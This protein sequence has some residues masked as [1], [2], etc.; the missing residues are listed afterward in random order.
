MTSYMVSLSSS[1]TS[2]SLNGNNSICS[3]KLRQ[4]EALTPLGV[5]DITLD[6]LK[7]HPALFSGG[8]RLRTRNLTDSVSVMD[9]SLGDSTP[10]NQ[11]F[12][13]VRRLKKGSKSS[14]L[15]RKNSDEIGESLGLLSASKSQRLR[16]ALTNALNTATDTTGNA[17]FS[18]IPTQSGMLSTSSHNRLN[19]LNSSSAPRIKKSGSFGNRPTGLRRDIHS[20]APTLNRTIPSSS[21]S[22]GNLSTASSSSANSFTLKGNAFMQV[23]QRSNGK[24]IKT[25]LGE[26]QEVC[27]SKEG[28]QDSSDA[29]ED[30]SVPAPM[31]AMALLSQWSAADAYSKV[32]ITKY[33]GVATIVNAMKKF[34]D[35][36]DIQVYGC[37]ILSNL[38]DKAQIHEKGGVTQIIQAMQ[39]YPA[40]IGVQSQGLDA[41]KKQGSLLTK[42]SPELLSSIFAVLDLSKDVFLTQAGKEGRA[43]LLQFL[44]TCQISHP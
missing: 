38:P 44:E 31:Q 24:T 11:S 17:S 15:S 3:T 34:H 14:L 8:P 18:H 32:V 10:V 4:D 13:A 5:R 12:P 33:N 22:T 16:C 21:V 20:S 7:P 27:K 28:G 23:A 9:P 40:S 43:Y 35:N 19:S 2:D 39:D 37:C 1:E 41:L 29:S 6:S 42:E 25:V 26:L 36:A 30:T